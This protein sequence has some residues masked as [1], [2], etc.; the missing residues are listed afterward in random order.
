LTTGGTH[1]LRL[2]VTETR[3]P[4]AVALGQAISR[5]RDEAGLTQQDLAERGGIPAEELERIEAGSVDADWG[6][7][8]HLAQGLNVELAAL[9]RLVED[10]ERGRSPS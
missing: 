5:L 10:L 6:T 9:F 4:H 3:D 2:A 8:R 7:V 1:T